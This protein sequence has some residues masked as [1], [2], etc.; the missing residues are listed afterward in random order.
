MA[1]SLQLICLGTGAGG[2]TAE[3]GASA[4]QVRVGNRSLLLDAGEGVTRDLLRRGL[5]ATPDAVLLSHAHV[6][7]VAGLLGLARHGVMTGRTRALR[8][9][10]LPEAMDAVS[11]LLSLEPDATF[12]Q[13]T[14]VAPGIPFTIGGLRVTPFPTD[15][16]IPSAGYRLD[17]AE[18]PGR[19]DMAALAA[20]GLTPGPLVGRL[21]AGHAVTTPSGRVVRPEEVCGPPEPGASLC[22]TGDTRPS[23]LVAEA[24]RG[25][26]LLLHDATYRQAEAGISQHHGHST[27]AQA[28][29]IAARAGARS[30]VL[31]H[32]SRRYA[33]EEIAQFAEEATARFSGEITLASDGAAY[34]V[35]GVRRQVPALAPGEA[36]AEG[37][38][39][40]RARPL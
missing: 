1:A 40:A 6:D 17:L 21:K 10:A 35:R 13:L 5:D 32:F 37:P 22:Y 28:G 9:Y 34:D 3:R 30:L 25:V 26:D 24:A 14:P 8:I 29:E 39:S 12:L 18:Q 7:H 4:Y 31:T 16:D 15:H 19:I 20:T 23:T 38:G 11:R 2:P 33:P 36:P 27:A